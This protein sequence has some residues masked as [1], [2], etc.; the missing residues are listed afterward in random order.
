MS[1]SLNDIKYN[2]DTA[3]PIHFEVDYSKRGTAK[4]RKCRKCIQKDELRS[5]KPVIFNKKEILSYYHV[6]CLFKSFE[7]ARDVQSIITDINHVSGLDALSTEDKLYVTK[8][9]EK[10]HPIRQKLLWKKC[11]KKQEKLHYPTAP[12]RN[13]HLQ[14]FEENAL[15]V[16]YTN[17][18]Q[19]TSSKINELMVKIKQHKPIIIAVCEVKPKNGGNLDSLDYKI[20][21]YTLHHANLNENQG[22]GIVVYTKTEL[23]ASI[24]QVD[25]KFQE[26][27][28][29]DIKLK[30]GDCLSFSCIYRSPTLSNNTKE[31][32]A[33]LNS[34]ISNIAKDKKYSHRCIIGDFNFKDIDWKL[35]KSS[36]GDH[37][38]EEKFIKTLQDSFLYQHI[39]EPTRRRGNDNPSTLDLV[40][41]DE[42][43]QVSDIIYDAPLG[44]SDHSTLVFEFNCYMD[45]QLPSE[46]YNYKRGDYESM[47]TYINESNWVNHFK[48]VANSCSSVEVLWSEIK[49][50]LHYLRDKFVQ[51][52][53]STNKPHW[54]SK[55]TVPL[56][57]ATR[58]TLKEK[59]KLFRKLIKATTDDDKNATRLKFVQARNKAKYLIRSTKRN[60]EKS[61]ASNAKWNA[62]PFWSYTRR[63][64]KT[65]TGVSAL[66]EDAND[67]T[68]IKFTAKEKAKIL[69]TQFLSVFTDEPE[70][71]LPAI[72]QPEVL[73][74]DLSVTKECVKEM[75]E[76]IN[77]NKSTGPD[78]LN[79]MLL[80]ELATC[81]AEPITILFNYT[82]NNG[83]LPADWKL[84][85]IIPI[86]K[87][88][89]KKIAENYR[90]ISLTSVLCKI[91]EKHVRTHLM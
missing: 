77:V 68:S 59:G 47:I 4:C 66:L 71:I 11:E 22:R 8:L 12:K 17:A 63:K 91:L 6:P 10:M 61:I 69:Q 28:Q 31:K 20:D 88:G 21:G 45:H 9:I 36:K 46:K 42:A 62:K 35:W 48:S 13:V 51:K 67:S 72:S 60:Y 34:L 16:L 43:T 84:G 85:R 24:F 3:K 79:P 83:V 57:A 81:L 54:S 78:D 41:T 1:K 58:E 44:K 32:S 73:I 18:D 74:T 86:Y 80:K 50:K 53:K 2:N 19:L 33:E 26:A 14:S 49:G 27:V 75:L 87:K 82:L 89:S 90:P 39:L 64:L 5:G 76:K 29:L 37:S 15:K 65:T 23:D 38:D 25:L 56:D 7:K 40:L 55:G 30:Q 70:G 52:F